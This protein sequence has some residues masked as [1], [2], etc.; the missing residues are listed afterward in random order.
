MCSDMQQ[1]V[2]ICPFCLILADGDQF[3]RFWRNAGFYLTTLSSPV[4]LELISGHMD[5]LVETGVSSGLVL[6][7]PWLCTSGVC[8]MGAAPSLRPDWRPSV[9]VELRMT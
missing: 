2:A 8:Q 7:K 6:S 1:Q 5:C 9:C 4:Q 3:H